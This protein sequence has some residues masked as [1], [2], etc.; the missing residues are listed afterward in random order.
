MERLEQIV[1]GAAGRI[2]TMAEKAQAASHEATQRAHERAVQI[3]ADEHSENMTALW[4]AFAICLV[5]SIGGV[6]LVL[7]GFEKIGAAL[8]CTTLLGVVGSF[9]SRKKPPRNQ[10]QPS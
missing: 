1:P 8:I 2:I 6:V 3:E 4:M 7:Q 5:F 9:L 10:G